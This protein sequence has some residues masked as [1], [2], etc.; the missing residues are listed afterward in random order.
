MGGLCLGSAALPRLVS[1]RHHPLRIYALL[2][3]GIGVLGLIALVGIPLVGRIYLAGRRRVSRV[4]CLRGL[5]AA[6]C[7]LPPTILMGASL[8]AIARWVETT[9]D[10]RFVAG[11]SLQQQYRG[12]G[13]RS[14]VCRILSA[15]GL[16][17]GHRHVDRGGNQSRDRGA[18]A[19]VRA[20]PWT[21][22][23]VDN[24]EA[25]GQAAQPGA[26]A[27]LSSPSRSRD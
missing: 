13:M 12:R 10:G 21:P 4:C 3:A 16:R 17:Y 5:V 14:A 19:R 27:H 26:V 25:P 7:L 18:R 23:P 2:E 8:P 20:S 6:V 1:R 11:V 9:P 15:A 22:R 24:G